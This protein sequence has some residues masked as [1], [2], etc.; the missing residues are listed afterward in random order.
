[1]RTPLCSN[2]RDYRYDA[3]AG[4]YRA[5]VDVEGHRGLY[6]TPCLRDEAVERAPTSNVWRFSRNGQPTPLQVL[7]LE[8]A[9]VP[10]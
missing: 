1:M 4:V 9:R 2:F 8:E 6:R 3:D 7:R 10:T 5:T